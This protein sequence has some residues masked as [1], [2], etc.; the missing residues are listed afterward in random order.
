MNV[1]LPGTCRKLC[2][3]CD[4]PFKA[5]GNKLVI[6]SRGNDSQVSQLAAPAYGMG[7]GG[8]G[9]VKSGLRGI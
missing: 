9:G 6:K 3:I 5:T 8:V 2:Q 7:G 1:M 4:W